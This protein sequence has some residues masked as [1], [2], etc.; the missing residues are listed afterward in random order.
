[1]ET[2]ATMHARSFGP[3]RPQDDAGLTVSQP[4][5]SYRVSQPLARTVSTA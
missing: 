4:T 2:A 1:M 3:E 5:P